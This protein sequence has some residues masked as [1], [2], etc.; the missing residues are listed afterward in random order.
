VN[1]TG[2]LPPYSINL[3]GISAPQWVFVSFPIMVSGNIET[4]L[5]DATLGDGQTTWDAA[6]W[7]NAQ[8][9]LDPWKTY[10]VG[11]TTNDLTT[12][13]NTMG[14]WLHL[15]ANGGDSILTV[16]QA[17]SYSAA[18]ILINLYAGWNLVGY[19]S[20][21]SQMG[22]ATLPAQADAAAIFQLVSPYIMNMAPGA[23]MFSHGQAYWVRVTANC[24]WT[25]NP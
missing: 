24:V 8:T 1:I 16:G 23:V 6:K 20:A 14:V 15:T 11:S 9:P 3:A 17:G 13:D 22:T 21:T 7:Y 4:I 5:N 10:R 19:P 2:A 18:P 12:I 25:V